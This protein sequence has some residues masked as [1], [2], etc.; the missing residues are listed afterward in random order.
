MAIGTQIALAFPQSSPSPTISPESALPVRTESLESAPTA[1]RS[2]ENLRTLDDLLLAI[3]ASDRRQTD[4]LPMLRTTAGHLSRYLNQ[5]LEKLEIRTVPDAREGFKT[6]LN[7]HHFSRNSIRSYTIDFCIRNAILSPSGGNA[8]ASTE[9]EWRFARRP[10][11]P[12]AGFVGHRPVA[13]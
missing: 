1:H 9:G 13:E 5:T 12:C 8:Y 7:C 10:A 2:P 6:Y 4:Q 11:S 3:E